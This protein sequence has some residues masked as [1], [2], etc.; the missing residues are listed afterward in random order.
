MTAA[1]IAEFAIIRG[2]DHVGLT[3]PD[4]DEAEQFLVA[5]GASPGGEH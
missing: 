3:V 1:N 2:V 4:I 5:A